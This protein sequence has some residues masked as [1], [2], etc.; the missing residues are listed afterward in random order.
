MNEFIRELCREIEECSNCILSENFNCKD[1]K[2][3]TFTYKQVDTASKMIENNSGI[4]SKTTDDSIGLLEKWNIVLRVLNIDCISDCTNCCLS[5]ICDREWNEYFDY[6]NKTRFFERAYKLQK[7][8]EKLRN[9]GFQLKND[10]D[11]GE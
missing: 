4:L 10:K 1:I 2:Y 5:D 6:I 8:F 9:N 11:M 3:P 7:F